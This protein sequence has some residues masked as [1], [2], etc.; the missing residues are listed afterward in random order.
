MSEEVEIYLSFLAWCCHVLVQAG[1][2]NSAAGVS[3]KPCMILNIFVTCNLALRVS[4]SL[5]W[6]HPECLLH[7][8]CSDIC[9]WHMLLPASGRLLY[10]ALPGRFKGFIHLNSTQGL[11]KSVLS[12]L[13]FNCCLLVDF[14]GGSLSCCCLHNSI[15]MS[16][17]GK[18]AC[19]VNSEIF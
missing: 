6:G 17:P 15:Y 2:T 8:S 7:C 12:R 5:N 10:C 4:R 1:V 16:I 9:L 14:F 13:W 11:V 18:F 3:T 19:D